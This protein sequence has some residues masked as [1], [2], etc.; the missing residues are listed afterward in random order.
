MWIEME[1]EALSEIS[2][3]TYVDA[4][5]LKRLES[6]SGKSIAAT[7]HLVQEEL[8]AVARKANVCA[9]AAA[10][11]YGAEASQVVDITDSV[12]ELFAP[13]AATIRLVAELRSLT[14][15]GGPK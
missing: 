7:L 14:A 12:I 15:A 6:E 1:I 13:G 2:R 8:P 4:E 5:F 3:R 11:V 10:P 9:I